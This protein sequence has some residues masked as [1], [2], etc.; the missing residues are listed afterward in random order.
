MYN[1][2][3]SVLLSAHAKTRKKLNG[4]LYK[5][6]PLLTYEET[7]TSF[8]CEVLMDARAKGLVSLDFNG[9]RLALGLQDMTTAEFLNYIKT[10]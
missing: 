9:F 4:D 2:L 7:G 8:Q 10:K 1:K 5:D 3:K 6:P